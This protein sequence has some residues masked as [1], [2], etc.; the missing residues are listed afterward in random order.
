MLYENPP[1]LLFATVDKF[2]MLG[3]RSEANRFFNSLDVKKLPPDLIIQDELHLLSGPLG[4]ITGIFESEVELL[5]TKNYIGPKIIASTA[6]TR[7]TEHQVESLYGNRDV[8]IFPPLGLNYDDSF[9]ARES[10][11]ES[12]RRY[13]GFIPT[14]KT[15]VDTQLQ[16]LAHLLIARLDVFADLETKERTN[17]YW[18]IVS[19]YNSLKD[20]GKI[21]NMVGAKDT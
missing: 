1:T 11:G 15:S 8:N 6:T 21:F 12:K 3:W 4:S 16:L 19:Y 9:F 20:V 5:C 14:G 13:L 10:K 18:T 7:N 17:D 2:A